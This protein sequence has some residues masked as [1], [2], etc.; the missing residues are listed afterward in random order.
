MGAAG[1]WGGLFSIPVCILTGALMWLSHV[2]LNEHWLDSSF[3]LGFR[4][5]FVGL[6]TTSVCIFFSAFTIALDLPL[7]PGNDCIHP[8]PLAML[9]AAVEV[10]HGHNGGWDFFGD[11]GAVS[12][13]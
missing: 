9:E 12:G 3:I 13:G 5:L 11:D 7:T 6:I 10:D 1:H 4:S 2:A 8:V